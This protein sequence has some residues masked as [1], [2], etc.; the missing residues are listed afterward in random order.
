MESE[1]ESRTATA[2]ATLREAVRGSKQDFTQGSIGRSIFLLAVPMVM[3]M[4]M[5]SL[6][7]VVD[8]FFVSKLGAGAVA[9]VGIT[10]SMMALLYALA[11]GLSMGA[12]A[13]IARR[14][15]EKDPERASITAV[16]DISMAILLSLPI[17]A[18][19]LCLEQKLTEHMVDQ[20]QVMNM[21]F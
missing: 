8:V 1:A 2:W 3:E 6:F 17:E 18:A 14:I 15:G 4:F 9:A 7:A 5:E 12:M 19:G 11:I 20:A 10:E 13:M 21:G 16:Q